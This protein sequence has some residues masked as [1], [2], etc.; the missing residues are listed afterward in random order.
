MNITILGS[1]RQDSIYNLKEYNITSIKEILSYPHYTKEILQVIDFCKNGNISPD[2]TIECFRTPILT[3]KPIYFEQI[4]DEYKKTQ[5]FIVEIASKLKYKYNNKY[6]H[7]ILYDDDKFN[8]SYKQK[9]EIEIQNAEEIIQDILQLK[10][11]L[12]E[13]LI[14]VGHIV[15]YNKG[16]RHDLLKLIEQVCIKN[17]IIFINPVKE[18][19]KEGYNINDL[20]IAEQ[21]IAHYNK[22]GHDVIQK[23]YSKFITKFIYNLEYFRIYKIIDDGYNKIRIGRKLDGGYIML[24]NQKISYDLLLSCGISN[25]ISFE[26]DFIDKYNIKCYAFDGTI[27]SL[28]NTTKNIEFYKK[29][30]S[31][32]N[33]ETTTNLLDII[34]LHENIFLKMDI[35]TNEF[36][37]IEILETKHLLKL[38]QIVI[39][40][41]FVHNNNVDN[42]FTRLSFPISIERRINCLKKIQK[43]HYLVHLHANNCCGTMIYNGINV[44]NVFECTYIRKDLCN[45]LE[46]GTDNIPNILLDYKNVNYNDEIKLS[47]Y[48]YSNI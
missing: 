27:N 17:N 24:D 38:G 12:K 39:E 6:V 20:I 35:E 31:N 13:Q 10:E 33:T 4:K 3:K 34:D 11:E 42:L 23:I 5:L 40:F 14:I 8:I 15:T 9:I 46:Y 22:A 1:C 2:E 7:H 26:D 32:T 36:Q 25:D 30:I 45:N 18:I 48:P 44:P 37:W 41:H 21:V 43:T 16:S 47:G 19:E 28:P 29:N